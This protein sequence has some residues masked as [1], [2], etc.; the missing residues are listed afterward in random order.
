MRKREGVGEEGGREALNRNSREW[1]SLRDIVV[2]TSS[3]LFYAHMVRKEDERNNNGQGTH[4][5]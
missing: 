1:N 5:I 4:H 3:M 2:L